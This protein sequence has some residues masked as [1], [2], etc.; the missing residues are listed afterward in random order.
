MKLNWN[1]FLSAVVALGYIVT[2]LCKGGVEGAI[3]LFAFSLLPLFCIWFSEIMGSYAGPM[4]HGIDAPTPAVLVCIAGWLLL[5]LP[6]VIAAI[7][8]FQ[9]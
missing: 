5:L 3:L 1:R 6:I 7:I 2:A 9:T 4:L 8:G